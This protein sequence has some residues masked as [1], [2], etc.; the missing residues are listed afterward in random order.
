MRHIN[1]TSTH[2]GYIIHALDHG[3]GVLENILDLHC[4]HVKISAINL[5]QNFR[6]H[7]FA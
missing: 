6:V 7:L 1:N 2:L 3:A 5:H 4:H